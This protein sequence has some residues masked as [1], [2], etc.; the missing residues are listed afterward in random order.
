MLCAMIFS[1]TLEWLPSLQKKKKDLVISLPVNISLK[2]FPTE[3]SP[4]Y[5]SQRT[6]HP[7]C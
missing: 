7:K 3:P 1:N 4:N 2:V 6:E 5:K